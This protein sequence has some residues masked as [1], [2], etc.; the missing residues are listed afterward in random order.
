M[1]SVSNTYAQRLT[2]GI[3]VT[4]L[5]LS[6]I[7]FGLRIY[8]RKV[9]AANLWWDD[10]WMSLPMLICIAMSTNDFV[11][12]VYGSGQHQADL[13]NQTVQSFMKNLYLYEI[14][15]SIGVFSV[16]VGILIFY[17]RVFHTRAFRVSAIAVGTFSLMIFLVNFFTFVFQCTPIKSFWEGNLEDCIDRNAFYLA[18][19][20][21]NV[22]GDIAV[23]TLPLPVVWRL[24]T[25][26]SKKWSLS[27]LFL[28]GA[29]VCIAS[30]FRIVGVYEIDPAD[31]TF[32]N[33]AGGLWSTVEVEI[34]FICANL[35]AIRP[36]VFKWFGLGSSAPGY[37]SGSAG[38]RQYGISSKGATRSGHV[39]LRSR[40]QE[41]DV[42]DSDT[43]ALTNTRGTNGD[44]QQGQAFGL[45]EIVVQTDIGVSIDSKQSQSHDEEPNHFV[46]IT[47]PRS[48]TVDLP[49][50]GKD[51]YN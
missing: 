21:I 22:A 18:S 19:A 29:F 12:L 13:D 25:S 7:S 33:L 28:L 15:W 2:T 50:T 32:S 35:P 43:E 49:G 17:W 44:A 8:A 16:K 9:S 24:H 4:C 36:V 34:G 10:Y 31:F 1:T 30:I 11:G 20:I 6:V 38:P 41:S 51:Y 45:A 14:F 47:A 39:I 40:N 23:L 37:A 46:R 42:L 5:A 3:V 48:G 26:R 27:F